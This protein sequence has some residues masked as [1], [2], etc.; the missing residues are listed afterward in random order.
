MNERN[1]NGDGRLFHWMP[2]ADSVR[3]G[4]LEEELEAMKVQKIAEAFGAMA[5]ASGEEP[6]TD[7]E[8]AIASMEHDI[9][10]KPDLDK[11]RAQIEEARSLGSLDGKSGDTEAED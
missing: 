6:M 9:S 7:E 11:I 3:P 4:S 2:D 1:K 8:E 10:E 5:V